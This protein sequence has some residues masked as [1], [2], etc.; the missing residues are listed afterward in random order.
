MKQSTPFSDKVH[1]K[2]KVRSITL[3]TSAM[4][5]KCL[6]FLILSEL[7]QINPF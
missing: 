5:K 2:D 7:S 4:F 3:I 1:T 6:E